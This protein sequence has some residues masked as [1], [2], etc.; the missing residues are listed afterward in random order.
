MAEKILNSR[1][2]QKHDVEA[3]WL[4]AT[5]FIPKPGELIV[6]DVD[7][8]YSYPRI[9]I[10]D[11]K[12]YINSLPFIDEEGNFCIE[13][14]P[15]GND[16]LGSSKT[17]EQFEEAYLQGKFI[18]AVTNNMIFQLNYYTPDGATFSNIV[19]DS[20]TAILG[21]LLFSRAN[22]LFTVK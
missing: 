22:N 19:T 14:T 10:G 21:V 8:N 17:Y 7:E 1:V 20:E 12:N 2:M 16:Q 18:Y 15:I 13:V 5:N 3:N 11:G 9:K 6:Y 4:K